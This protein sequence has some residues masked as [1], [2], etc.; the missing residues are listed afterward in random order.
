MMTRRALSRRRPIRTAHARERGA[1]IFIVVLVITM[2]TA[3][4]MFAARNASQV[5]IAAGHARQGMQALYLAEMAV[6]LGISH[7]DGP[8]AGKFVELTM[9]S[10]D[11]L[12]GACTVNLGVS[13]LACYRLT[14]EDVLDQVQKDL[15]DS[16]ATLLDPQTTS[17]PG[18]FGPALQTDENTGSAQAMNQGREGLFVVEMTDP[19]RL[20]P[21][22]GYNVDDPAFTPVRLNLTGRGQIRTTPNTAIAPGNE[23]CGNDVSARTATLMEVRSYVF[24]P[25]VPK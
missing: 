1:S 20:Q 9:S 17:N 19:F 3:V 13:E 15:S 25:L 5:N 21:T 22:E 2:L 10:Q 4:G 12:T 8:V 16:T 24:F 6:E 18:S 7:I 23:W 11:K 14:D